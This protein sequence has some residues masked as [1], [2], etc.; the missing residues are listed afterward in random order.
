MTTATAPDRFR[1]PVPS[2]GT[3]V[4]PAHLAAPAHT[5]L[6][7]DFSDPV[8]SLAPLVANPG[9]SLRSIPWRQ[10]PATLREEIRLVAWT[11]I[12]GELRPTFVKQRGVKMRT[13]LSPAL[14]RETI[15]H[16]KS[17]A[18]WLADR[19]VRSLAA[20][21][22]QVLHDYGLHIRDTSSSRKA[23]VR[24]FTALI[25]L[26]AFDGLSGCPAGIARPPWDEFGVDD[27]LPAASTLGGENTREPLA[28]ETMGPLLVWAVR[29]VEDLS[30]DILAAWRESGHLRGIARSNRSTP[31][32]KAAL[33]TF[34][35]PLLAN[36]LPLPSNEE[37]GAIRLARDYVLAL[38]GASVKQLDA[39]NKTHDLTGAAAHRP[40]PCP[41]QAPVT[42][43][44]A[45]RPWREHL[46]YTE[47][48]TLMRHLGTAA[49][50]VCSYL[51][52]MR[53]QEKGAELRLMQHPTGRATRISAGGRGCL[54][55]HRVRGNRSASGS[56]ARRLPSQ[57]C[58]I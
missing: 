30:D 24:P 26:W 27:Y 43:L 49:F 32:G 19:E 52:G 50:I 57:Q 12:N 18:L 11:L 4:V 39:M 44:I 2:P 47:T 25:R 9:E 7:S 1:L 58:C 53:P 5:H 28:E 31:Q 13:R 46:D 23:A 22:Q 51:T 54:R 10:F 29:M 38:T 36:A 14:V 3:P 41:L 48:I 35:E 34:F 45:G 20:C 40:G 37:N 56:C 55:G 17:F 15:G 6:N 42:G 21:D 8:W 33:H 16:W